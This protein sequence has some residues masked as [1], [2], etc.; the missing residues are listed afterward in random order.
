MDRN[1]ISAWRR[2]GH[3]TN[4]GE[5]VEVCV[6]EGETGGAGHE[7]DHDVWLLIRDSKDPAGGEL[8]LTPAEWTALLLRIKRGDFEAAAWPMLTRMPSR[9]CLT[10]ADALLP[11]LEVKAVDRLEPVRGAMT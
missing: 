7:A 1:R 11:A 9:W 3:S 6:A 2:S 8:A 5:C 10:C 4:G